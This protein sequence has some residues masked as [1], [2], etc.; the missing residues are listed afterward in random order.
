MSRSGVALP[1][2]GP[3]R[4]VGGDRP[5]RIRAGPTAPGAASL[6]DGQVLYELHVGTFTP[7]GTWAAAARAARRP[8]R[9]SASPCIELMP[10]A[11][12]PGHFGWGYDGVDLFAPSRLYG[13]PDDL[14]GSSTRRTRSGL[15]RDPRRRL[16]PPRPRR[17]L[18]V[19]SSPTSTSRSAHATSGARRSNFDGDGAAGARVLRRQRRATGSTSSTSTACGSTRPRRIV[20][21]SRE[22][23][24]RRDRPARPRGGRRAAAS[25]IVA[26]NEPQ[27][28]APARAA[29]TGGYGLDARLE[30]R[31]PP[32]RPRRR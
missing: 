22:H 17:Q 8:A 10:V 27:D 30:R 6:A 20:D 21:D 12:F 3:A 2:R 32:R 1:A 11:D 13:T 16:Q 4:P 24:L 19:R 5:D 29:E 14:R 31:L 23:I 7:E 26:E 18:P 15:A 9:R 28:A 25:S